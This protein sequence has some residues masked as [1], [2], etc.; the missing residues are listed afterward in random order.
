MKTSGVGFPDP[1]ILENYY[2]MPEIW[3]IQRNEQAASDAMGI[4]EA[5]AEI[6]KF[7]GKN[8]RALT[9]AELAGAQ[10][11]IGIDPNTSIKRTRSTTS[12]VIDKNTPA[13]CTHKKAID[14]TTPVRDPNSA[15]KSGW[16]RLFGGQLLS[17]GPAR[18]TR[19][20]S[21]TKSTMKPH[22]RTATDHPEGQKPLK[23][24]K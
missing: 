1:S 6:E 3:Q 2:T 4:A 13:A 10:R 11:K 18:N 9:Y 24:K 7:T 19:S 12:S 5:N 17:G 8:K 14:L 15:S 16:S 20:K 23:R 21:P 22:K